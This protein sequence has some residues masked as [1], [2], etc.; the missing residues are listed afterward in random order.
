MSREIEIIPTCVPLVYDDLLV[1]SERVA[2]FSSVL[3]VDVNDGEFANPKTWPDDF[4]ILPTIP[5]VKMHVHAMVRDVSTYGA[6]FARAGVHTLIV[7]GECNIALPEVSLWRQKG[8]VEFGLAFLLDTEIEYVCKRIDALRPDIVLLMSVA[9]IGS[10]GAPFDERIY[11]RVRAVS[12][13]YPEVVIAVDGGI[14][15]SNCALLVESGA[16]R[17][18]IG[19]SI[20]HAKDSA[21]AYEQLV[22]R[23]NSRV[24]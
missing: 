17:L 14:S 22:A 15:E 2:T 8:I 13:Q 19:S 21:Y 9:R 24:Q 5:S 1:A 3:H 4:S 12:T 7:H 23:E 18:Y 16:T 20:M 6:Y 10:Q 11:E